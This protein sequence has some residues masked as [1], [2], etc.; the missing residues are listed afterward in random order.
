MPD[1]K[2]ISAAQ[3][4]LK[5]LAGR[6]RGFWAG[7]WFSLNAA[8]AGVWHTLST[9]PNAWL[10]LIALL[11]IVVAGWWFA[12]HAVEWAILGLTIFLVLALEAVNTAVEATVDLV[13][14]HYHPLAKIAKDAAAGAMVFAVL[15]SLWV[16]LAIFGPRIWQWLFG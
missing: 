16:A 3:A 1:S 15:G 7:R 9:Q 6:D 8:L 12:I 11:L 4:E 10:E 13:A 2:E 5:R 14:P